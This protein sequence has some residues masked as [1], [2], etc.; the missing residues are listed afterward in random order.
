MTPREAYE[1]IGAIK[2]EVK[3]PVVLH[4]HCTTGMAY[5]TYMKAIEAGVDVI[6]TATSCFS[7]GTSQPAT[8][9][10]NFALK[11]LGYET[12]LDDATLKKVNDY[13]KPIRDGY[14]KDGTLNPKMLATDTDALNYKVP[15]GM[16]SNLVSQLKAQNAMDKFEQVLEETPKVRADLGYPPLVTPMSQ[17]VGVQ[18]TNNVLAGERYKN[19]SKEVK[20]YCRGEYGTSPAPI[21]PDVMKK[22]LG[23][24]KPIE[25]RYADTL[26]PVFEKTKA[27][28]GDTAKSDEDVLSYILFP[29]VAEKFF[30]ARKA[31]EEKVVKY[32]IAPIE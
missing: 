6:D 9:T 3:I 15:G 10:I 13:F 19:I 31:K 22:V 20:A 16:L 18:A 2:N 8:E 11:Q 14:L 5:M 28:L 12:G 17:M 32:T 30:D 23:D 29:Q 21:N 7:G 4:T 25:G 1:L 26:E 27:E 24:E